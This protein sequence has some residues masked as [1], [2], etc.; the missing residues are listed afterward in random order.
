MCLAYI[1]SRNE[2][3]TFPFHRKIT[4]I[5]KPND[6]IKRINSLFNMNIIKSPKNNSGKIQFYMNHKWYEIEFN[7]DQET[8][9]VESLLVSKLL[10]NILTPIFNIKDE[11]R[12]KNVH[13]IPGNQNIKSTIK[14]LKK[15]D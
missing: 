8:Q 7:K 9:L 5:K 6:L 2:L 4:N 12:N 15:Y 13:F 10:K 1:V 14:N 11:R 3:Q